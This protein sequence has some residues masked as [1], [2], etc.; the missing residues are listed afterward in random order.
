MQPVVQPA[1]QPV[2]QPAASCIRS[3]NSWNLVRAIVDA[4]VDIFI[5]VSQRLAILKLLS[6]DYSS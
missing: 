5:A 4:Y 3:F 1:V 2:V 6:S